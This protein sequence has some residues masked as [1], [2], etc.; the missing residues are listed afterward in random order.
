MVITCYN[1]IPVPISKARFVGMQMHDIMITTIHLFPLFQ[2][3]WSRV[4]WRG[5]RTLEALGSA[6]RALTRLDFG[7]KNGRGKRLDGDENSQL[8]CICVWKQ[9]ISTRYSR[10]NLGEWWLNSGF[11]EVSKDASCVRLP[12]PYHVACGLWPVSVRSWVGLSCDDFIKIDFGGEICLNFY[13][14]GISVESILIYI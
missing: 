12:W 8:D 5:S 11:G 7:E 4:T 1:S 13:V 10:K 9:G 14:R 6:G 2:A 3:T